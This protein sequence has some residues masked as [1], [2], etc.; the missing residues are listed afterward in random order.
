LARLKYWQELMGLTPS[1][2]R[3]PLIEMT[4]EEKGRMREEVL[5]AGLRVVA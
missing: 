2:V 3:P 1:F 5:K 4:G